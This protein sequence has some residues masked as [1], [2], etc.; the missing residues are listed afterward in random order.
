[1][2]LSQCELGISERGDG[3]KYV[4]AGEP[5]VMMA[6]DRVLEIGM[7]AYSQDSMPGK[8]TDPSM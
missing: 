2:A 1:M 7:R 8:A 3:A 4:A 5:R 6:H